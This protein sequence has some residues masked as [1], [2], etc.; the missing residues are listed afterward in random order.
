MQYWINSKKS[1]VFPGKRQYIK[2]MDKNLNFYHFLQFTLGKPE[3]I[4]IWLFYK[5]SS[6]ELTI[7]FL[8]SFFP[9][10]QL[11]AR[12]LLSRLPHFPVH[13]A[14]NLSLFA[15]RR[16]K[17]VN[18]C[19]HHTLV[20]RPKIPSS[21]FFA[22]ILTAFTCYVTYACDSLLIPRR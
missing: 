20:L 1:I 7:I 5:Q 22:C 13:L 8:W 18:Y 2:Y 4:T 6:H 16:W 19:L 14:M 17:E 9:P 15:R 12:L 3:L 10:R 11:S 21:N